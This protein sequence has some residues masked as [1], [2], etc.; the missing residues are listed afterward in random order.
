MGPVGG[1]DMHLSSSTGAIILAAGSSS[2]M[3]AGRHKLLLPLAGRPV[4]E[5]VIEATLA[6]QARPIIFVLGHQ[7]D[8]VRLHIDAYARHPLVTIVEN[9][10]YLQGMSTSLHAGVRALLTTDNVQTPP[11]PEAGNGLVIFGDKPLINKT[12]IDII[13]STWRGKGKNIFFPLYNNK[14]GNTVLFY[15]N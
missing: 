9:A 13:I 14:K 3:G 8:Q 7:A 10:H 4:L 2:R 1:Y 15:F 11:A 6:S 5:H 12:I